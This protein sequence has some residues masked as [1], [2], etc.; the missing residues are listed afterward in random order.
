MRAPGTLSSPSLSVSG[1]LELL[2]ASDKQDPLQ[3]K[4]CSQT[5]ENINDLSGSPRAMEAEVGVIARVSSMATRA[6]GG[7]GKC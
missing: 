5:T 3:P 6:A 1:S 4:Q 2:G 7:L